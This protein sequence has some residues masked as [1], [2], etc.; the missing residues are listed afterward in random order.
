MSFC[1]D[2]LLRSDLCICQRAPRLQSSLQLL[3][4]THPA[5]L[6]KVSNTGK[7]LLRAVPGSRRVLWQ[8]RQ[9]GEE[10]QALMKNTGQQACLLYPEAAEAAVAGDKPACTP[11]DNYCFLLLDGTWQQSA[12]ML[13]QCDWLQQLPRLAL[14]VPPSQFN[15][16]RNQQ[17]GS[18]STVEAAIHLLRLRGE[19]ADAGLLH[20]YFGDFQRACE[21][22]RSGHNKW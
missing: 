12:K 10:L 15:L 14:T 4:L 13:R 17:P 21:A 22:H 20:N 11:A 6:D 18:V 8:R 2:C 1:C 16:R 19:S 9:S 7:L 3:L 5:E